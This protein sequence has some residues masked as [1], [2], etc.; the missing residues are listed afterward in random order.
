MS[1]RAVRAALLLLLCLLVL[2]G[3]LAE[4]RHTVLYFYENYCESCTPEED[5]AEIFRSL[6]GLDLAD[7]DYS[8][9]N[10]VRESGKAQLSATLEALGLESAALPLTV[11]DGVAYQ[12]ADELESRLPERALEWGG[13][14]DSAIVYLYVPACESCARAEAVLESL[15]ETVTLQRGSYAIESA[16]TVERIDASAHSALADALFQAYGVPDERRVTPIA[17]FADRYLSGADAIEASLAEMV[18]L[19]WAAGGVQLPAEAEAEETAPAALTLLGTLGAGLVGGLNTCALS[20][21]LLFLSIV[22][23]VRGHAGGYVVC[24]LASKFICYLLIGFALL[25]VLQQFSPHWLQ[26]LARGLLTVIGG[27]LAVVNL[28]DAVQARREN[29]GRIRNQLPSRMRRGLHR[30]IRALTRRRVLAPAT[31]ALGFIVALGEFL[32]AGQLYLMRL[33][34]ALQS[35]ES[36]PMLNLVLYC[37]AF[38]APSALLSGL[39]LRG[40]SQMEVSEFLAGHMAAVKLVTAAAMLALILAAWLL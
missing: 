13:S 33:L 36:A 38:L 27:A 26:P 8:A 16:V 3:A 34:A 9:Y 24:F 19:G 14:T 22:L 15:P 17:F 29:Y 5:F 35:G 18:R 7:C 11:V 40:R 23:E 12:G 10:A 20:M 28:W 32:C 31:V 6:T 2:P 30:A 21:L 37:L 25:G 4:D 39:I 1:R